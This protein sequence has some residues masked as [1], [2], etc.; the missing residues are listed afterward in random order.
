M[1]TGNAQQ[2]KMYLYILQINY[3]VIKDKLYIY[4]IGQ[5]ESLG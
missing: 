3:T 2:K 5:L 4:S 1:S